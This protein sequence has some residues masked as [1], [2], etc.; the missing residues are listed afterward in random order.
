MTDTC[1]R[2]PDDRHTPIIP[3]RL[4]A[5][6]IE[7]SSGARLPDRQ[8]FPAIHYEACMTGMPV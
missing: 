8:V 2:M 3:A 1:S 6:L 5:C 4:S 7:F